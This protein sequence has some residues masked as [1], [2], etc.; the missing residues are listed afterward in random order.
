MGV[1]SGVRLLADHARIGGVRVAHSQT[2][3]SIHAN[4]HPWPV[5]SVE[6][7]STGEIETIQGRLDVRNRG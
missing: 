5:G 2:S 3:L 4:E 7:W 6:I 1:R